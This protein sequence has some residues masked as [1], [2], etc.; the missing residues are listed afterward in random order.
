MR[1]VISGALSKVIIYDAQDGASG[2]IVDK[3]EAS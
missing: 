2:A 1:S 3:E